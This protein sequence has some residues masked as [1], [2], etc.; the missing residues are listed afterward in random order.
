MGHC[1]VLQPFVYFFFTK[2]QAKIEL[3]T[4]PAL[5]ICVLVNIVLDL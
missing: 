4:T 2:K 5:I 1:F 3:G